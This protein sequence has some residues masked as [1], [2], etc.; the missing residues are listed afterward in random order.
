MHSG[1]YLAADG[2][3]LLRDERSSPAVT[4]VTG[5]ARKPPLFTHIIAGDDN[6]HKNRTQNWFAKTKIAR[7]PR[8]CY[9]IN[10]HIPT[11]DW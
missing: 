11:A 3:G 1:V 9:M 4:T 10:N 5:T 7:T 8:D 6:S 2:Y